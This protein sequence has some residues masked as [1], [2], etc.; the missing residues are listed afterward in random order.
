M[1]KLICLALFIFYGNTKA[2][3]WYDPD[4]DYFNLFTQSIIKDKSYLPFL[5][6]YSNRFYD[7]E[8]FEIPNESIEN[9]QHYFGNTLSYSETKSLVENM[10]MSELNS[11]KK[12][13]STNFILNKLGSYQK[14]FEGIDYLIEAKYL[15]PFMRFSYIQTED[16]FYYSSDE[17]SKNADQVDYD[18]TVAALTSLYKA[19]QNKDIKLRYAYQLVRFNHYTR[20]YQKSVD[21]FN[22]YAKPLKL[23]SAPYFLA[24][25]QLAGAQRGL[26]QNSEANWNFF[27]VFMNSKSRKQSAFVSMK[28]SDSASFKNILE[29]AQTP[30]EKEM[31]YFLLTYDD[32]NNPLP[33]MKKMFDQNPNS[34]LLKVL[35]ARSINQLER[36]YLPTFYSAPNSD[37]TA[38]VKAIKNDI[39]ESRSEKKVGFWGKIVNF[40]KSI[41]S[42]DETEKSNRIENKNLSGE[43]LLNN[44]NR[45]PF[46][47]ENGGM[48]EYDESE[49]FLNEFEKL[50]SEIKEKSDD[51][52]WQ[53]TTAY[54]LFLKKD[55]Q[56]SSEILSQIKT[57]NAEYIAQIQRMK[58]LNEIV[59]QPKID[60]A[61]ENKLMT[62]YATFFT[63]EVKTDTLS[64]FDVPSTKDFLRDVL[65]N[66]YFLQGENGKSFLMN[67]E[68][69]DLQYNPN[70][71]LVKEV[72]TFYR[73]P[74]K[75]AFEKYIAL[76]LNDIGNTDAF[77]NVIYG[78]FAMR[79]ADF[80]KAKNY[81]K[82]ATNFSGIPRLNYNYTEDV[83]VTSPMEYENG[84][85]DGYNN[86]SS[87][88]FGYNKWES[89]HSNPEESMKPADLSGFPFIKAS[90]NKL[91]LTDNLIQLKKI[92]QGKS[93][94][95]AKANEL[96]GN[97]LYN[98]SKLGYYRQTFV[99]DI[100]NSDG[101]KYTFGK[102]EDNFK[103]YYKNYNYKSFI[104]PGDFDLALGYYQKALSL[105]KNKEDQAR[106]LFQ[107]ASAE[108][109]KY[110]QY[111]VNDAIEINYDDPNWSDKRD[112]QQLQLNQV[113]NT[114]YRNFFAKLKANYA[115]T[116]TVR[117]LQSSCLYFKYYLNK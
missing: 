43:E 84:V 6:T 53:I 68:L 99:M 96:I 26:G 60:A 109:G 62:D 23:Q 31:A 101:G 41:F 54:L 19:A 113:K 105:N 114:R 12:G 20:N 76:N 56:K 15:E 97:L 13:N 5:L 37:E 72:E 18:K 32:Y 8:H 45:I 108:Q 49:G 47:N 75:N 94:L 70:V 65:A 106:I 4:Y 104:E 107:M 2:C 67:N 57:N 10:P 111:E 21:A 30:K 79:Q 34:D 110:Y 9:W 85:Y 93:E 74:N 52:F 33:T 24:L 46:L 3:G 35:A 86:I 58:M 90:M 61:F 81:Y 55:Y 77:F 88:I 38:D 16:S 112:E 73:K 102:T 71:K 14:Y 95:S 78:D 50:S 80:T 66:R 87:L 98:T 11:F 44:P 63:E 115:E 59:S 48:Y 103:Y 28:L 42:S 51:E 40:F 91:E 92:S 39:T 22:T 36:N 116:E 117:E 17:Q 27:S 89:F 100:D 25:D 82:S 64:Y 83:T 69:S 29:R 7:H 1:K